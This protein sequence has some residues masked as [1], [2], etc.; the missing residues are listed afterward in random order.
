MVKQKNGAWMRRRMSLLLLLCRKQMITCQISGSPSQ[1]IVDPSIA[2]KSA[3]AVALGRIKDNGRRSSR[4]PTLRGETIGQDQ[5]VLAGVTPPPT[6][7]A[8]MDPPGVPRSGTLKAKRGRR[9]R[10]LGA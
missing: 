6:R 8:G 5:A 2:G 3:S 9:G 10:N 4:R 7:R 1:M